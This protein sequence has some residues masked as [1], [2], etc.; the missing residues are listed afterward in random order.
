MAGEHKKSIEILQEAKKFLQN[1]IVYTAM[2][3][4]Y[5]ALGEISEA[6]NRYLF[7]SHMIPSRFYPKYLLATLYD[8]TGQREK[9]VKTAKELL[10]KEIKIESPA[11]KEIHGAMEQIIL[12]DKRIE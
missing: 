8:E 1:T 9:A 12:K 7:A 2:G 5:K 6:E 4:S 10:Q 11:I 3:D